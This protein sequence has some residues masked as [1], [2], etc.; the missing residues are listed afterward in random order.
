MKKIVYSL[1]VCL[2]CLLVLSSF[3]FDVALRN[4]MKLKDR[5]SVFVCTGWSSKRFHKYRNCWGLDYCRHKIKKVTV[6]EAR[7]EGKTACKVCCKE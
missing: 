5:D 2:A 7:K 6:K 3:D 4:N 1:L